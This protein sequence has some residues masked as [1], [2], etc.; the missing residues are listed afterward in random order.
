MIVTVFT[1]TYNRAYIL[2]ILYDSLCRQSCKDFEWVVVDDGSTDD[3]GE[4]IKSFIAEKKIHIRYIAQ[5]N[6]GKHRAINR[7][8]SEAKG[9]LFFIVDSDDYLFDDAIE[10]IVSYYTPNIA[11]NNFF[12]GISGTRVDF[13][14]RRI[15]GELDCKLLDC[16]PLELRLKYHIKGDMAEVY[17]TEVLK[18]YP[19]P[20]FEGEKFCPEALV[21]N[22]ISQKYKLHY[23]NE[24]IYKCKY[25]PDGLTA[26]IVRLRMNSPKSSLLYYSELYRMNIPVVQKIK[27]AINYWRFSFCAKNSLIRHIEQIGFLSLYAYPIG[28]LFHLKDL[29]S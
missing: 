11:A 4:L 10:K 24:P 27:A 19:F 21:W 12:A 1:P 25:L 3:T 13:N 14:G 17:K 15:G 20:T 26:K 2:R 16:S 28:L 18:N 29:R 7:G 6:G 9:E 5:S 8:L 23:V 22:R